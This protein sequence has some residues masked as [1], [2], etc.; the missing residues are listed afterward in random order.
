M[1]KERYF[2]IIVF[3]D[4]NNIKRSISYEYYIIFFDL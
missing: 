3:N 4:K 2:D 1:K